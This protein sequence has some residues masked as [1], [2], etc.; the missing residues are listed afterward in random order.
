MAPVTTERTRGLLEM[1]YAQERAGSM[2]DAIR[3]YLV[4]AA[5][6][7]RDGDFATLTGVFRRMAIAH[8]IRGEP[9]RARD[10]GEQSLRIA[11]EAGDEVLSAEALCTLAGFDLDAGRLDEAFK[12]YARALA[13]SGGAPELSAR[14]QQNLGII[15]TERGDSAGAAAHYHQAIESFAQ[16]GDVRGRAMAHHNLGIVHSDRGEWDEAERNLM[17]SLKLADSAG[18]P[19]LTGLCRLNL[20]EVYLG[21]RETGRAL[22]SA[23]AALGIFSELGANLHLADAYRVIGRIRKVEGQRALALAS[24]RTAVEMARVTGAGLSAAAAERELEALSEA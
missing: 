8:H 5:E 24:L 21:V 1:A 13:L 11:R 12:R 19:R 2:A 3:I 17:L 9:A 10:L 23:E 16:A 7:Q 20:A 15:A 14:I 6:A 4:I 18:D 22:A